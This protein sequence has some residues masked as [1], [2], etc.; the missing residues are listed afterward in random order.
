MVRV[1]TSS[2]LSDKA[3]RPHAHNFPSDC[4][5]IAIVTDPA[6]A[7]VFGLLC[8]LAAISRSPWPRYGVASASLAWRRR[9]PLRLAKFLSWAYRGG[10]LRLSGTASSFVTVTF[11]YG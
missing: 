6:K 8:S 9:V 10:L 2:L 7:L 1:I 4:W 5:P 11:S 3:S